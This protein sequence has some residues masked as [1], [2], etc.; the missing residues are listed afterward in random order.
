MNDYRYAELTVGQKE[1]FLVVVTEE[2]M[3]SF[4]KITGDVNP[5]HIDEEFVASHYTFG[6]GRVVYGM[7][8]AS[9]F[10]TLAGVY[11][12]GKYC[13]IQS[14]ETKFIYPVFIG[15]KLL[16]SGVISELNDCVKQIV[17]KVTITNQD[18]KKVVKGTMKLGTLEM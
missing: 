1:E 9:F 10:S 3:T 7:L 16:V 5:L 15:D 11:L 17:L 13:L 6:K 4:Q 14:V 12:P 2:M 8:T 18:G